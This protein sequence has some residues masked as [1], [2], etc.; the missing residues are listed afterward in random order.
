MALG[1][2]SN[3]KIWE[4]EFDKIESFL[5]VQ[6][7]RRRLILQKE[8]KISERRKKVPAFVPAHFFFDGQLQKVIEAYREER[9]EQGLAIVLWIRNL[10]VGVF[11]LECRGSKD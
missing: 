10:G 8:D 7:I 1:G 5:Y 3:A 9:L 2:K 11:H 4:R 6:M